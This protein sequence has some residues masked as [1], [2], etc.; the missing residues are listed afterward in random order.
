VS[1]SK[2]GGGG[3]GEKENLLARSLHRSSNGVAMVGGIKVKIRDGATQLDLAG[4]D[5]GM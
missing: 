1:E 5:V 4:L 2:G 3:R